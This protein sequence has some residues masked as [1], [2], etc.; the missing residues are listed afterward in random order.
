MVTT[1]EA[2]QLRM[3]YGGRV[4]LDGVSV[5]L[6]RAS[7]T[8]LQGASGSGKTT[9]LRILGQLSAPDA[10]E[11]LLDGTDVLALPPSMVRRRVALVAQ[12]PAMFE[13]TV[14]DNLATGLRLQGRSLP[15]D[16]ARQLLE[17]VG[18][19]PSVLGQSARGL[20]GGE[21]LRVAMAR[22]LALRPEV[23]LL[24]E[25][26]AALDDDRAA[27]LAELCLGLVREGAAMLAVTHD[28]RLVDRL[29]GRLLRL[30][31]GRL[32]PGALG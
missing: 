11:M 1:F 27:V 32:V 8:T 19:D 28:A 15:S 31:N 4:L 26:T 10:G 9:L 20:S 21:K 18:L 7:S 13:G 25:P 14:E 3:A 17:R 5:V 24:D 6:E 22:A 16:E 12:A 29:R 2:R 30:D 23:W